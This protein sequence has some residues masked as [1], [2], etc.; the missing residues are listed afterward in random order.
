MVDHRSRP[1]RNRFSP[2]DQVNLETIDRLGLGWSWVIPKAGARLEATPVISDGVM[3][4]TGP[5][6][7][8]FALDARTGELRWQWDPGVPD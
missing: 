1:S 8:V 7:Y 6:S 4:A 3:Y 5:K 2:L